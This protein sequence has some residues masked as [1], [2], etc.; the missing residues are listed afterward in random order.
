MKND[1][2]TIKVNRNPYKIVE[3]LA[4]KGVERSDR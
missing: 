2:K 3:Y 4:M 1:N